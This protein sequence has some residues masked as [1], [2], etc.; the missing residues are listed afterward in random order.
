MIHS[1]YTRPNAASTKPGLLFLREKD[2]LTAL[3]DA[4]LIEQDKGIIQTYYATSDSDGSTTVENIITPESGTQQMSGQLRF[5]DNSVSSP[6]APYNL[7]VAADGINSLLRSK[8]GGDESPDMQLKQYKNGRTKYER[9]ANCEVDQDCN[10]NALDDRRYTVFRGNSSLKD[11]EL[12]TNGESFQTWGE[13]KSMRFAVVSMS[14]PSDDTTSDERVQ[15]Q[16]W[17]AT[18]SISEIS[19][20]EDVEERKQRIMKC[21]SKW[22]HPIGDLIDSTPADEILMERAVAHKHAVYPVFNVCQIAQK[23]EKKNEGIGSFGSGPVLLFSGDANMAVDPVL[24][25]GFTIAMETSADLARNLDLFLTSNGSNLSQFDTD[26]FRNLI[27]TTNEQ[28]F[29]RILCLLRA[30]DLVQALA[31]P[32]TGSMVGFL[33]K[34]IVRPAINFAPNFLK[35]PAFAFVMKYSLGLFGNSAV[36]DTTRTKNAEI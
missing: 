9:T 12:G 16:V 2:F 3:R 15:K 20:I 28:R 19:A 22:H 21:F 29:D 32:R 35:K 33:S 34:N 8:Y 31:Q 10:T 6:D 7:V 24:A 1:C 17:F 4:V 14:H 23:S 11:S 30:T 27:S 13:Q 25:Q 5:S 26:R 36:A 18:T